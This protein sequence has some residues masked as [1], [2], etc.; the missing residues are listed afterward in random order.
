MYTN[1]Y[2]N[3]LTDDDLFVHHMPI[4]IRCEDTFKLQHFVDPASSADCMQLSGYCIMFILQLAVLLHMSFSKHPLAASFGLNGC[5]L[6]QQHH[7]D[8]AASRWSITKQY[9]D[10]SSKQHLLFQAS[11]TTSTQRHMVVDICGFLVSLWKLKMVCVG[12]I[13]NTDSN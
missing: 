7:Q 13:I 11:A 3:R 5:K 2:V 6:M 1:L 9:R 10:A 8:N 4:H 12:V